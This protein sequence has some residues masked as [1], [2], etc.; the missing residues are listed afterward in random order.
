MGGE[1]EASAG[2]CGVLDLLDCPFLAAL[3]IAVNFRRHEPVELRVEGGMDRD[4]LA[5]QV[6][7]KLGDA[8][9]LVGPH[10]LD[11]VTVGLAFGR[12][13]EIE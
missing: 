11:F 4:Q 3:G 13:A 5:L 12:L 8:E 6:G 2:D 9:A 7:R 1:A 10:A